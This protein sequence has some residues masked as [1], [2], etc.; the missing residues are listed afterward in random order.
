MHT[1]RDLRR[2]LRFFQVLLNIALYA[3]VRCKVL[4]GRF[5]P[6]APSREYHEGFGLLSIIVAAFS[7]LRQKDV[8]RMFS[9]SSH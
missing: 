6:N 5:Y 1:A 2:S 3:L 9:Y 4:V 7:L 8:K